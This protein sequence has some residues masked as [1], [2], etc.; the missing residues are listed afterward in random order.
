LGWTLLGMGYL[1]PGLF[2][3]RTPLRL[4]GLA[5]LGVCVL[6]ALFRDLTG[7]ALPHRVL[8]YGVLG[9]LLVLSSFLYVRLTKKEECHES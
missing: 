4:P 6:K 2:S 1:L 7:L 9:V 8:S 5:L 3:G